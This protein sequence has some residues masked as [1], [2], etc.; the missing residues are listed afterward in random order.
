MTTSGK[1]LLTYASSSIFVLI[2]VV[3]AFYNSR[4]IIFGIKIKN[5]NLVD[6]A[7]MTEEVIT[8]TGN[9]KNAV[10]LTLNGREISIDQD[11][12]FNETIALLPG[13]NV[14][15]IVAKDKFGNVDQKHYQLIY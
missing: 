12:N 3:F 5:V 13:Y 1:K 10:L 7:S 14:V 9:A 11:K 15:D 2:I 4:E 6:G 8:V